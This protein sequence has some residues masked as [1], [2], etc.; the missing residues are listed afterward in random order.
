MT[1][2]VTVEAAAD[3][4]VVATTPSTSYG[5][6]ATLEVDLS[7]ESQAYLKFYVGDLP[8]T[9]TSARLRLYA[10]DGSADGPT[11]YDPPGV[12]DW[13]EG[14]TWNTRPQWSYWA[15]SSAGAVASGTWM[16]LDVTRMHIYDGAHLD[17]YL[18]AD[19]TDGVTLASSEHPDPALRPRLVLTVESGADHPMPG[20]APL[21]LTGAPVTFTPSA[22]T[23]VAEGTPGSSSG[24]ASASLTADGS[25]RQEVHLRFSVQGLPE[26]VQRAVLR[27][28]ASGGTEDG[29]AVYATQGSWTESSVTWNTRPAQV[30]AA[31]D[32]SQVI[33][34]GVSVDYD[35]TDLVR[36]NGEYTLGLYGTSGDGV[37]FHSREAT[38]PTRRP[39][40]IVWTGAP[41]TA[42][43]DAC[44]TRTEFM[45]S[46]VPTSH[47]T[48]VAQ[49][50]PDTKF[51]SQATLRVDAEPREESFLT[52][53]VDL[54]AKRVRRV[55]LRLYALDATGN[56]P[57][58][59]RAAP[60]EGGTT[61][62]NHR[63]AVTGAALGDLGAVARDGWVEYDV[64]GVVTAT[65]QYSFALLP[66]STDGA[67]FASW[68]AVGEGILA[69]GAPE[70]VVVYETDAFCSYRG[71]KPSGTTAWARQAGGPLAERSRHVAPAPDGGFAALSTVEQ[72]PGASPWAEQTD[73]VTLH[74]ADGS[75][76][77]TRTFAQPGLEL[78]KVVVTTV[79]NVLVAGSYSGAPDLGKGALPQGTGMV[80]VKLSPSGGVDWTRG[81]V[82]WYDTSE[83]H[84]DNPMEVLDLATDAHGS[85]V[86]VGT[87]WGYTDFGAGPVYSGK[88]YPYD[89]EYPNSYVL[90]LQWDG[91]HLWSKVLAATSLRGTRAGSVAVDA[92]ENVI[93]G[94]WAGS[95]TDLGTGPIAQP[96]AFVARYTVGGAYTW[97][98]VIPVFHSDVSGV[99]VLPDGRVAFVGRFGGRFSFAGQ[100]YASSEPDDYEGGPADGMLGLLSATGQDVT[101]RQFSQRLFQDLVVDSTGTLV[102]SL[103]GGG[104][105]L[106]LGA[107]GW[108][109]SE[110]PDRLIL[111]AFGGGLETRWVRVFDKVNPW[112]QL[113]ATRDGVVVSGHFAQ[114]LELDG[115]WYTPLARREDLLRFKLRP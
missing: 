66:D 98:R 95:N 89:D 55:L 78:R 49:D 38:D 21:M 3:A 103:F 18:A 42:P 59:F 24:G 92:G 44:L 73:V 62:W 14:V 20:P 74:R 23:F 83:E 52:F 101:L 84:L 5:S 102:T 45:A 7:P 85:A 69:G 109:Y 9:V 6:S 27:L 56:G 4:H 100:P 22:D 40:L 8:G 58:L 76:A 104:S 72:T 60:F 77:W 29:P 41:K 115:T 35:V 50:S 51:Y 96:G 81:F 28:H 31:L 36:G 67:S 93:V 71:T 108:P 54:S 19:S 48:Y 68:E 11:V 114:T 82:A 34:S 99:G 113:A 70:L 15:I 61:D 94:G 37:T 86:L 32:D 105:E 88:P 17:F 75:I 107:V 110:P 13:N 16:E 1:Q 25:P 64:T 33:S 87:F 46:S 43:T 30:G 12:R 63:P 26:T 80:V 112:V 97:S 106:G 111:A 10:L 79:G 91:A 47:D 90:K 53:H 39:Q 2:T 65:G 57:R